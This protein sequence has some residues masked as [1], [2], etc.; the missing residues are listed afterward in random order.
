M[1][2]MLHNNTAKGSLT[3]DYPDCRNTRRGN[4]N[5]LNELE[6]LKT[7]DYCRLHVRFQIKQDRQ[8]NYEASSRKHCCSGKAIRITR[9]C[10]C[11]CVCVE[12][13][14]S[15]GVC[16]QVCSL[17]YPA[18]NKPPYCHQRSLWLHH[19]LHYLINATIFGGKNLLN[20]KCVLI[21]STT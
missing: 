8:C 10:M 1:H 12:G 20:I 21:L 16:L 11:V 7:G 14:T 19:I 6:L 3:A 17:N 13:C 5:L 15:V 2:V 4:T 18:C 9:A